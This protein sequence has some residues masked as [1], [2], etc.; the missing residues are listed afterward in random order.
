MAKA[1]KYRSRLKWLEVEE[2]IPPCGCDVPGCAAEGTFKAPKSRD[3]KEYYHFCLEHVRAYNASWDF[4]SGMS[5]ADIEHHLRAANT[6]ERPTWRFGTTREA[7]DRLRR[8]VYEKMARGDGMGG[9]VDDRGR[10]DGF[11]SAAEE[12]RRAQRQGRADTVEMRALKVLELEPPVTFNL[13]KA[14]YKE[15]AKRHHPDM[16]GGCADAEERLKAI[17]E[18]YTILKNAFASLTADAPA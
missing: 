1:Q 6:W 17:N 3:L 10:D 15:L 12:L 11:A 2:E 16:N 13:I 5:M 8:N 7:E 9:R 4:F 14:R 18:A